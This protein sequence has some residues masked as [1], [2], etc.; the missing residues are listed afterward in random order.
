MTDVGDDGIVGHDREMLASD[1][2]PV[3]G[4]GDEDVGARG[5]VFHGGDF[6]TGHSSLEGIDRVDLGDE[7]ASTI[8]LQ[9][10]GA[11]EGVHQNEHS[12]GQELATYALSNIAE[13]GNYGDLS[14]KHD[15]GST[16]DTVD[17]GLA[18]AIVVVELA[19]GDRII[20][21]DGSDLEL[22]ISMHAV[23]VVNTSSGLLGETSDVAEKIRVL[24]VN[25]GGEITTIVEDHVQR[26]ATGETFNSLVDTPLVFL[27]TLALPGKDWDAGN[28]N[29]SGSMVLGGEDVLE[30]DQ[31]Y[32]QYQPR[33]REKRTQEDQVTS[34]P[35]AMR[36]SIKTAVW[37]VM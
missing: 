17:E 30:E 23:E 15:V 13:S 10:L 29:G 1:N 20:D 8:R 25:E 32:V 6:V 3:A 34:A 31:I 36:V 21:I 19:L 12:E 11:L 16:L 28:G 9:R 27:L 35:R 2:V 18:A 37:M 4:G 22:A 24:V 33:E 7:N 5:G 14:G 26:P